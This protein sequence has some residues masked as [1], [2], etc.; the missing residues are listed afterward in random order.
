MTQVKAHQ[1]RSK[2]GKTSFVHSYNKTT[3]DT[4]AQIK[5]LA[6]KR[7]KDGAQE[8]IER[9]SQYP[10]NL[11]LMVDGKWKDALVYRQVRD[12]KGNLERRQV[13][14]RQ[15]DFTNTQW[16][17]FIK[18]NQPMIGSVVMKYNWNPDIVDDL[19]AAAIRGLF[20]GANQYENKFNP[21]NPPDLAKHLRTYVEGNVKAELGK[22]MATRFHFP[23]YKQILYN[24]FKQLY[25][26]HGGDYDAI[27]NAMGLKKK[28]VYPAIDPVQ[29]EQ[30]LPKDGYVTT[31]K[32]E[33]LNNKTLNY[34]NRVNNLRDE[35]HQELADIEGRRI[36]GTDE[37]RMLYDVA[38][39]DLD[40]KMASLNDQLSGEADKSK[41]VDITDKI[42][43]LEKRKN[44]IARTI[45][46]LDE[47]DYQAELAR[48][49]QA[50]ETRI[51]QSKEQFDKEI[52]KTVIPGAFELF[53]EFEQ[54]MSF[55]DVNLSRSQ[56]YDDGETRTMEEI[57]RVPNQTDPETS[58][59]IRADFIKNLD[60]FMDGID[61][62]DSRT[63]KIVKMHLGLD[64][65]NEP[66][67]HGLWGVPMEDVA[68]IVRNLPKDF[69]PKDDA[70]FQKRLDTWHA[71]QPQ[72]T[73]TIK[74]T[75]DEI[76]AKQKEV[77]AWNSRRKKAQAEI[78]KKI[79]Q[80]KG[81]ESKQ[82]FREMV[83]AKH[84]ATKESKPTDIKTKQVTMS[85][86]ELK[87][88]LS[89]WQSA[90]PSHELTADTMYRKVKQDLDLGKRALIHIVPKEVVRSLIENYND[91]RAYNIR[92]SH[93]KEDLR[94]SFIVESFLGYRTIYVDL[95][96]AAQGPDRS[97]HN[98]LL[99]AWNNVQNLLKSLFPKH[100]VEKAAHASGLVKKV[101]TV[102]RE[103]RTFQQTVWVRPDTGE[104]Q[105]VPEGEA[106]VEDILGLKLI[107]YSDK[108]MVIKGNT[109]ANLDTLREIKNRL[110]VGAYNSTLG[111]W[112][113]P[114]KHSSTILGILA[115]HIQAAAV[116]KE[117]NEDPKVLD[118]ADNVKELKNAY[119]IGSRIM[120]PIGKGVIT[121]VTPVDGG[122]TYGLQ[123]DT[124]KILDGMSRDDFDLLPE[125]DEKKIAEAINGTTPETR[126]QTE[127]TLYGRTSDK[128]DDQK[129]TAIKQAEKQQEPKK[130]PPKEKPA[131]PAPAPAPA[132]PKEEKK[133]PE[134]KATSYDI[135]S[136]KI[137][138]ADGEEFNA[139]DYTV[140]PPIDI[141]VPDKKR[142]L[143]MPRPA[144]IPEIDQSRFISNLCTF[145]A[146][147]TSDGNYLVA[148]N[149]YTQNG[150]RRYI[151]GEWVEHN[152]EDVKYAIMSPDL[153]AATTE[154]YRNV[155][156]AE[157]S[158]E[159]EQRTEAAKKIYETLP[160]DKKAQYSGWAKHT[161]KRIKVMPPMRYLSTTAAMFKNFVNPLADRKTVD[162]AMLQMK[163]DMNQK[164]DD[165][166]MQQEDN[167][168]THAKGRETSYG[169]SGT[170]DQLL[171]KMGV[172]V[173]MQ[174]G[175]AMDAESAAQIEKALSAVYGSFGD[176]SKTCREYGLKISHSGDK[177]MHASK[178]IGVFAPA[179]RA[180]GVSSQYGD[181]KFGFTLAHEFAHFMDS[182]VGGAKKR[183]FSSDD[184]MSTAGKIASL[185]RENM[186][187]KGDSKYINRSCECFA[188]AFEQ[189]HAMRTGGDDVIKI[190]DKYVDHP[191]HVN[192]EKFNSIIK[193][194]IEQW[195]AENKEILKSFMGDGQLMMNL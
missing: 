122:V 189:Y 99:K 100:D 118:Q 112:V 155:A 194:L 69:Y 83:Y 50:Y 181:N 180:I 176:K 40:K 55:K 157:A 191:D 65:T 125:Q 143:N 141:S 54:L 9:Y 12:A 59:I 117:G 45:K 61:S 165:M 5:S 190:Q 168:N 103:G 177:H 16:A 47:K 22:L 27:Y 52:G 101:V 123:L 72:K 41:R 25:D 178:A 35:Y 3:P 77:N 14:E 96:P 166:M 158:K 17:S 132:P 78:S 29:A 57:V 128:T 58:M 37:D 152:P 185:F 46:P 163:R 90:K 86:D 30:A 195:I 169:D 1:R 148:L 79:S 131:P 151:N 107:R 28:D 74:R 95:V 113:F 82:K 153:L 26:E 73:V 109:F 161:A 13:I 93:L 21:E 104:E 137:K 182:Q 32:E 127:H 129:K 130:E 42:K 67:A 51:R 53:R 144:Y 140:V 115:S 15:V 162:A 81:L 124:G 105:E 34:Q 71:K 8:V 64:Q 10:S 38:M 94:K 160:E 88:A 68:E 18:E 33:V 91:M 106:Y 6:S 120:T 110:G 23:S 145:D 133:E 150:T 31:S 134:P 92:K 136:I 19:R 56:T 70:D 154:Y 63:A 142:I 179:F 48:A 184:Y 187:A 167:D 170:S 102:T 172:K 126:K 149:T 156:R 84:N 183:W 75:P 87:S 186:N 193:P 97:E 111:G 49:K 20:N 138:N 164:W 44:M 139:K 116:D 108:G 114:Y 147:K 135:K 60:R 39:K 98:L 24:K 62:L 76:A 173:K 2:T 121:G 119:Q 175:S 11:G 36:G 174:N 89:K 159:A 4:A 171:N 146:V 80:V 188:R 43:D 192:K 7:I 85:E 66:Y